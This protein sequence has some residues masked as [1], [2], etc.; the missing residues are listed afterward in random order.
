[1]RRY[2]MLFGALNLHDI[3]EKQISTLKMATPSAARYNRSML[4]RES[5]TIVN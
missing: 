2:A 4:T 3:R 1:M 5:W